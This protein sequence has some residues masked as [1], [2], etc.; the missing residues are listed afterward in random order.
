[1]PESWKDGIIS[2]LFNKG[3]HDSTSNYR[4]IALLNTAYKIYAA[5]LAER[6]IK[7]VKQK[8][9]LSETQAGFRKQRGT[10]DNIVL[11]NHLM[12]RELNGEGQKVNTSFIDLKAAFDQVDRSVLW[13]VMVERG[14]RGG[15]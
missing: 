2:P 3:D 13:K 9:I 12:D 11:L 5:V 10:M 4:G 6:L 1:M 7:E 8:N 15:G 14:V